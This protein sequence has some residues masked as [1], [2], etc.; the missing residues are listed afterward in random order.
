MGVI[1]ILSR[2]INNANTNA[3][4][5]ANTLGFL[6]STQALADCAQLIT[7]VKR[8][9]SAENCPVIA[10]GGSYG[11]MLASWLRLKYPH[12]AIGALASSAPILY[13]DDLTPQN[14]YHVVANDFRDVS[15]SCYNT[16][17][18]SW[19]EI[20]RVAGQTNVLYYEDITPHNE[21]YS[22][23]TKNYRKEL[24]GFLCRT[25][26]KLAIKI[27]PSWSRGQKSRE[28]VNYLTVLQSSASNSKLALP[29]ETKMSSGMPLPG[30][31]TSTSQ[32]G[33]PPEN[34]I[35][36]S[37]V[38]S[39]KQQRLIINFALLH[40]YE[41][42]QDIKLTLQRFTGN[43]IFS[44]GLRDPYSAGGVLKNIS[45][46]IIALPT[47]NGSHGLDI[48]KSNKTSD[49]DWLVQQRNTEQ[50]FIC[51]QV[52]LV[53]RLR[54]SLS[55]F[56]SCFNLPQCNKCWVFGNGL[57]NQ[58]S[59]GGFSLEASETCYETIMKSWAQIEKVASKPD[60][61]S[62]LSKKFRTCKKKKTCYVNMLCGG[63]DGAALGTDDDILSKIFAG[64]C[65]EM[66]MPIGIDNTK[67]FPPDPFDLSN[68]IDDCK[69]CM[70]CY[71]NPPINGS[72]TT[73]GYR[74][75][76]DGDARSHCLDIL[77][78]N[79]D[80]DPDWLVMQRKAEVEI[81]EG[82][83]SK[84]YADLKAVQYRNCT[85]NKRKD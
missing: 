6:S 27:K 60:G 12:I 76:R 18:Q 64:R 36:K 55:N 30:M 24:C 34:P 77:R 51:I 13:F 9:L 44:N 78:A 61:L 72:E 67:M 23:V 31:Y 74:W 65:S 43:I 11:G 19:S 17:K 81:I 42:L 33:R 79:Q 1:R 70:T 48:V 38:S 69:N 85:Q 26:A 37:V 53:G 3:F 59:T 73:V 28:L 22:T 4:Q 66:V 25:L 46:S 8:N 45:D 52:N 29:R 41:K 47:V 82:W 7:D 58:L 14:G 57:T 63:I 39:T 20:D 80:S 15:E 75:Q 35:E 84:Y 56:S 2:D 71:V 40:F 68:Y 49:P 83:I 54:D 21:Y 16:I 50:Q 10:I 32:Y 62:I 5:D